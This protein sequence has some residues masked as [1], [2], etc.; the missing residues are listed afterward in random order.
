[1]KILVYGAGALGSVYAARLGMA[2]VANLARG[3]RLAELRRNGIR[4]HNAAEPRTTVSA[5][6][7]VV[8]N[9]SPEVHYDLVVELMHKN[10]LA[11]VLPLL[12][13]DRRPPTVLVMTHNAYG[14]NRGGSWR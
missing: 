9:L 4:L 10:Q 12:A 5:S 8:E 14:R 11:S 3:P 13:A 2:D 1:M 7:L 6:M